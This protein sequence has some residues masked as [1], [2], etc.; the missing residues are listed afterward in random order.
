MR[1]VNPPAA[2]DRARVTVITGVRL[3]D[4]RGGSPVDNAVV[5]I[6]G[7][8]IVAA[9]P[10]A[11]TPLPPSYDHIDG[12]GRSVVP[13]L[14]D[15]HFHLEAPDLPQTYLVRGATA[16]RDPGEWI[17]AYDD[18]RANARP[19][20]RLFLTG[21]HLD[22]HPVAH[23]KTSLPVASAGEAAAAVHRFA[24]EGASAIKVYFRI[25]LECF[26]RSP[27]LPMRAAFRLPLTWNSSTLP[28]RFARG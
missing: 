5:V 9:G 10:S 25:P 13:G 27:T 23:P 1:E 17:R 3:V 20:P 22:R 19:A 15:V 4:G 14:I 26:A 7:D 16:L 28:R 11:T 18:V 6:R 2:A 21:P 8:K 12:S 24:D